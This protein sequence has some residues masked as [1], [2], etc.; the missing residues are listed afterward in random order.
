MGRKCLHTTRG[1][2]AF[3]MVIIS[4]RNSHRGHNDH[5]DYHGR[6]DRHGRR[7][8]HDTGD[9]E[10]LADCLED[11]EDEG[12]D[13]GYGEMDTDVGILPEK[14]DSASQTAK[15]TILRNGAAKAFRLLIGFR[16]CLKE[17]VVNDYKGGIEESVI[18][19]EKANNR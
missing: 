14:T 3:S 19:L 2:C 17:K 5:E 18:M 1:Y 13:D 10:W 11:L 4:K 16:E 8:E 12:D 15:Q 7:D 6:G 9:E